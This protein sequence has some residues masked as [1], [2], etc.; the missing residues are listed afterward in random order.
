MAIVSSIG[1]KLEDPARAC[2]LLPVDLQRRES[3]RRQRKLGAGRL[4][5]QVPV[6]EYRTY[7]VQ[8]R[9]VGA[10]SSL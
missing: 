3:V 9:C 7:R 4:A 1:V 5:G 10:A 8:S 6:G 2:P